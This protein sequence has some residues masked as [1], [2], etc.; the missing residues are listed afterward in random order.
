MALLYAQ[1]PRKSLPIQRKLKI[2]EFLPFLLLPLEKKNNPLRRPSLRKAQTQL[3]LL[4]NFFEKRQEVPPCQASVVMRGLRTQL[5]YHGF[6][7]VG[8]ILEKGFNHLGE[9]QTLLMLP[10]E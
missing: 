5:T 4:P 2:K 10:S 3:Y 1:K 7:E 9:A 6:G 8:N